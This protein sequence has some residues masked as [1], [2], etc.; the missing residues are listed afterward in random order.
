[1]AYWWE[2]DVNPSELNKEQ[3]KDKNFHSEN[4]SLSSRQ[5]SLGFDHLVDMISK[6]NQLY[7]S[8]CEKNILFA[9]RLPYRDV[10]THSVHSAHQIFTDEFTFKSPELFYNQDRSIPTIGFKPSVLPN[11]QGNNE[12]S[13]RQF[14]GKNNGANDDRFNMLPSSPTCKSEISS[15]RKLKNANHSNCI[16]PES[17]IPPIYPSLT[18]DFI[19]EEDKRSKNINIMETSLMLSKRSFLPSSWESIQPKS[20]EVCII[21]A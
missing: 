6:E 5:T 16:G 1:M 15:Q 10:K 13:W 12:S 3:H 11:P 8:E 18:N 19:L 9:P 14:T 21:Y 17:N 20:I 4:E 7:Q 2:P